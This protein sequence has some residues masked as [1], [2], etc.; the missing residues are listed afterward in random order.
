MLNY[1]KLRCVTDY[2][3]RRRISTAKAVEKGWDSANRHNVN[4]ICGY[5][6]NAV[7]AVCWQLP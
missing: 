3:V 4:V 7:V 5:P 1:M 6:R 2:A